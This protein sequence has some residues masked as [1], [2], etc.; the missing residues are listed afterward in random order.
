MPNVILMNPVVVDTREPNYVVHAFAEEGIKVVREHLLVG[1]ILIRN[2][3]HKFGQSVSKVVIERKR[4]DDLS[5][6]ISSGYITLFSVIS[7]TCLCIVFY[8]NCCRRL[9]WQLSRMVDDE[10]TKYFLCIHAWLT[11]EEFDLNC[12]LVN[13][14]VE[15][16]RVRYSRSKLICLLV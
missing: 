4:L 1:D 5:R 11:K 16:L 2:V 10:M 7:F 8:I 3:Y 9:R 14:T 13:T 12:N 15:I 6:C